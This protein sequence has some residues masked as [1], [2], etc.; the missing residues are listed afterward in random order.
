MIKADALESVDLVN[1]TQAHRR[2][3]AE[4]AVDVV[5]DLEG[6]LT[7]R[8]SQAS[9]S[10]DRARRRESA[11]LADCSRVDATLLFSQRAT[12]GELRGVGVGDL[13]N[14]VPESQELVTVIPEP[15]LLLDSVRRAA[16]MP[17]REDGPGH[18]SETHHPGHD[19]RYPVHG[20]DRLTPSQSDSIAHTFRE[21]Q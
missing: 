3:T 9:V 8:L 5:A 19:H 21:A 15:A 17:G 6:K 20:S 14:R 1:Q 2:F 11:C 4:P 16:L 13:L 7:C 12:V 18:T 10:T